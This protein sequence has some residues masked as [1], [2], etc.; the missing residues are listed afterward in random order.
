MLTICFLSTRNALNIFL[1]LSIFLI[2]KIVHFTI[3]GHEK[4]ARLQIVIII[5]IV[6][7]AD[8]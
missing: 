4:I 3:D 8:F 6:W 2:S 5:I 7:L 1:F